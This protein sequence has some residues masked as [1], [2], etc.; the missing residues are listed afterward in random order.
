MILQTLVRHYEDLL[1]SGELQAPGW[2]QAKISYA[3]VIDDTGALLHAV[4]IKNEVLQG[5]K[6][7]LVPR[8]MFVPAA[9]KR[10]SGIKSNFL[11][12]NSTYILGVDS[13]KKPKRAVECFEACKRLHQDLLSNCEAPAAKALLSFF[14]TWSPAQFQNHPALKDCAEDI[15]SGV[16][17][18]F[19]YNGKY[20]HEISE[21]RS[22]L[23]GVG[24]SLNDAALITCLVTGRRDSIALLH[25]PIKG[26]N[27]AQSSG[28]SLVSFNAPAFGSFGKE[29]LQG[30]NAP[31]GEY[32]AFAYGAALNHLIADGSHTHYIG[33]TIV[34]CWA[35]GGEPDYQDVF[36]NI[37]FED[38]SYTENDYREMAKDI[39]V[40]KP[41]SFDERLVDPNRP[42]YVLGIAPNAARLS[43]RFF[44]RSTFGEMMTNILE[45]QERL[46]I[47]RPAYDTMESLS[48]WRLLKET[49]NQ[50]SKEK[51]VS[52]ALAG[53]LLRSVLNGY[54]YPA[55]LLNG[56]VLRIR[57]DHEITRGRAAIIKAYYL[58]NEH[59][60][61]PKEVL[62][63]SLN[64]NSTNVAYNL[65]RLFS[66]LE[67]VQA[68]ANPGINATIKDRYFNSASATPSVIF[69]ILIN[70]A[71]KHMRKL[72]NGSCVYFERKMQDILAKLDE[73]MPVRLNLPQ[74]GSFQLGYYH[75]TQNRYSANHKED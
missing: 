72:D 50:K 24:S 75:Q 45:H 68:K 4:N 26:I 3:L 39:A 53:E 19:R 67:E 61:V 25:P 21:I 23:Q 40:G 64:P 32:A 56:V 9:V 47:E 46:K 66:V 48:I 35:E 17:L 70:L 42:F 31:T 74:Q 49:V 69:P 29:G 52:P 59:P 63:V 28:A 7:K 55:T 22:V 30:E 2:G 34:L 36:G 43:V 13:K 18:V 51:S 44:M 1:A 15:C 60:D 5:K 54:C 62:T 73:E 57:A 16:N 14:D 37:C 8:E 71:Q 27:G 65:G 41:F 11:W 12:D 20:I 6:T 58:K 10:S 38:S 33:D